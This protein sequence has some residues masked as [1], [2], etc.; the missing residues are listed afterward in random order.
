MNGEDIKSWKHTMLR[1]LICGG[2]NYFFLVE[3][4]CENPYTVYLLEWRLQFN[5]LRKTVNQQPKTCEISGGS[6]SLFVRYSQYLGGITGCAIWQCAWQCND[7]QI[8]T[9]QQ[10]AVQNTA[11][12]CDKQPVSYHVVC[13]NW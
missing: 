13:N 9:V 2:G 5:A 3:R 7:T 4:I 6:V 10:S 1:I 8:F 11:Y 12:A